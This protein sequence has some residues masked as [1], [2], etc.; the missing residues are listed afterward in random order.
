MAQLLPHDGRMLLLDEFVQHSDAGIMTAV[1]IRHDSVL[2]DGS[3]GVPAWVGMEYMAQAA[4]AYAGVYDAR[5]GLKPRIGL[6]LG[7]RSYQ[8]NVAILPLAARL[9]VSADLVMRDDADLMVFNCRIT[10]NNEV[11]ASGDIKAIRPADI[12]ALIQ[13]QLHGQ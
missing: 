5:A 1:T 13:E 9:I 7:T 2:C 4:C 10:C 11:L 12:H 3:R 8:A 6:L